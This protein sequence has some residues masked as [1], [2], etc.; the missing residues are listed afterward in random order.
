MATPTELKL[1]R[2]VLVNAD[3]YDVKDTLIQILTDFEDDQY[4]YL[5]DALV[6]KFAEVFARD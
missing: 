5:E 6:G 4:E 2:A 1:L 3:E